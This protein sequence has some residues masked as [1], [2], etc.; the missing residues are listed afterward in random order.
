MSSR[1]KWDG[2]VIDSIFVFPIKISHDGLVKVL[3]ILSYI[4]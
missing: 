1:I 4:D 3:K 2:V